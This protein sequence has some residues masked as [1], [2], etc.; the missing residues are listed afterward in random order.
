MRL[1]FS[2]VYMTEYKKK[3]LRIICNPMFIK[4]ENVAS[5]VI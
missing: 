3:I 4:T 2:L 1:L 5:N